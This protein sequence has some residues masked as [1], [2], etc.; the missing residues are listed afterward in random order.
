MKPV[1]EVISEFLS[2]QDVN[3]LS[4]NEYKCV[5]NYFTRWVV[6][7]GLDF[8]Q[9]KRSDILRYKSDMLKKRMSVYTI[10]LYLTVVRKLFEFLSLEGYYDDNIA[11]GVKSPKKDTE[12][13]KGYLSTDQVK[14]LLGKINRE[15]I[16]GKRDYAI[17]S[18]MVRTGVR[19][20]E[21]C[22]MKV[23]D[24]TSGEHTLI[25][26]QRKGK[27]DKSCRIG[28]TDNVLDAIHDYLVCRGEMTEDSPLFVTHKNGYASQGI[29]DFMISK[30]V[31]RYLRVIGLDDKCYT[32]HSL[33]HTAAILSLKAGASIYDVQQMLGHTSIETTRIYLRAIDAE[34]RMDNAA[35]RRLD[36]LF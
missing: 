28:V 19:R 27:V 12:Y 10:G 20:V 35:I 26:L 15:S 11:L 8:W 2:Y 14:E 7:N 13:R 24:I 17:I 25:S 34:K 30:M 3:A 4:R 29:S 32:C 5:V 36:E 22:R 23:G 21:V 18:L 6:M 16:V 31:K 9:L 33:R 1:N